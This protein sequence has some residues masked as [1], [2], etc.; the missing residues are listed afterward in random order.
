MSTY[1]LDPE[2][3]YEDL[4]DRRQERGL[5]WRAIAR[6]TDLSPMVFSRLKQGTAPDA[7]AVLTLLV[8]LTPG[9]DAELP[10]KP[11]AAA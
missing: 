1:R 4:D 11:M 3:L 6:E 8:W 5:S 9:A 10:V 2:A 7:H